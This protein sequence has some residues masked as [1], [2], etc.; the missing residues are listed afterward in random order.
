MK[1]YYCYMLI[2]NLYYN[3]IGFTINP[4]KRL[5]QHNKELKGGAKYTSKYNN[6]NYLF[7][8]EGFKSKKEALQCEWK[9]KHPNNKYIS[10]YK[11]RIEYLNELFKI[12]NKFTSKTE[13][14]IN[15]ND[16]YIIYINKNYRELFNNI[17]LDNN[18]LLIY[19]DMD[20]YIRNIL[21]NNYN[22]S[23]KFLKSL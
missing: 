2:N 21:F 14:S 4:N 8:I 12:G 7:I 10:S 20:I 9:L 6:W 5:K 18:I 16:T 13:K 19:I 22:E 15:I 23:L 3:Y 11:K 1:S 17:R